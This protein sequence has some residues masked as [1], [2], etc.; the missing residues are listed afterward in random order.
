MKPELITLILNVVFLALLVLGFLFGL[1]GVKKATSSLCSFI[2][3][4]VV[5]LFLDAPIS[6]WVLSWNFSGKS[7]EMHILDAINSMFGESIAANE[8]MQQLVKGI[9]LTLISILV[10]IVLI[11]VLGLIFKIIGNIVYRLIFGKDDKKTVEEVQIVNDVPQMTKK[12]VSPKKH[13]LLGGCIGLVHGFLLAFVLFMPLV[14]IVNIVNEVAGTNSASAEIITEYN[15]EYSNVVVLENNGSSTSFELKPAKD[16]LKEYL[17]A[18]FYT[19]ASALDNSILAKVGKVGNMSEVSLNLVA[20]TQINGETIKLGKELR[21]IVKV[22]DEFVDFATQAASTLGTTDIEVIF[23]DIVENPNNYDFNKLY[24]ICDDLFDSGLVKALGNDLLKTIA[25]SLVESNKANTE[26][27]PYLLHIQTA[28]NNYCVGNYK[29]KDDV[30]AFLGAFEISAKSGLIKAIQTQPFKVENLATVLLNEQTESRPK[31]EVLTN[32]TGKITSSNLL[33]KAVIEATNYGAS[34]LQDLMNGNIKFKEN[35]KVILPKIDGSKDIRVNSTELT[36]LIANAYK[37]YKDVYEPL[38]FDKISQDFLN[39]FDYDLK[40]MINL[41]GE[42]IDTIVNMQIFKDT[43][44]FSSICEAMSNSEYSAYISFNELAVGSNIKN[45]FACLAEGVNE[46]KNSNIV[47]LIKNINNENQNDSINAIISELG[48]VGANGKVLSTRILSPVLTCSILKNTFIYGLNEAHNALEY[49]LNSLVSGEDITLAPFNTSG[50]ISET[51]NNQIISLVE[52]L[53]AYAKD[54]RVEKLQGNELLDTIMDSNLTALGLALDEAKNANLFATTKSGCLYNDMMITLSK[55]NFNT[56]IDFTVALE[57]DFSWK[58]ELTSLQTAINTINNVIKVPTADGEKGLVKFMLNGGDFNEAYNSLN[59]T[60]SRTLQPI[61]EIKLIKPIAVNIVNTINSI[62]K[63]FVGVDLGKDIKEITDI[64]AVD[65]ASQSTEITD[66]ISAAVDIDFNEENLDN[67]DKAKLNILLAKL[68]VN[69]KHNGVFKDSYNALLLKVADMINENIKSFVGNAGNKIQTI[70]TTSDVLDYSQNIIAVLNSALDTVKALKNAEFKDINTDQLIQFIN[71][72]YLNSK[73]ANNAFKESF[74]ALNVYII[75]KV[76]S[77][78]AEFV[79]T[80]LATN[81]VTYDGNTNIGSDYEYVQ[82]IVKR[83]VS[84]YKAIPVG[85]ELED[86][87]SDTLDSL[88]RALNILDYTKPAY[89]ALNNKL[90]NVVTENINK[91]TGN[92]VALIT[93]VKD[94]TSQA[95]DIKNIVDVCLEVAPK[96]DGKSFKLADMS[97]I[98]KANALKLLNAIQTNGVKTDGVFKPTYDSLVDFI[99]TTNGTTS[100]AIYANFATDGVIDWNSFINA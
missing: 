29:L 64:K 57:S 43:N 69:A 36:N 21:T 27:M 45:Q 8:T 66:V 59:S 34:Y 58:T 65:I 70:V 68:E 39:I 14:G 82:I 96:L 47:P 62:I 6:R 49:S 89:N 40:P 80:D 17:P 84:A 42:E 25:D 12:T 85:G 2:I 3:T 44:L 53:V 19:Y 7:V 74:N 31:N 30:K 76:N 22:Y 77:Q 95:S 37:I 35:A 87:D 16:L 5:V 1:K 33:Q 50:L 9:P 48:V 75:N 28:V 32:L 61:F 60:N 98:D 81:I 94:L 23:N 20:R 38:D 99:A 11:L 67:I 18:E 97:D 46:L 71:V 15:T 55:S 73:I 100:E 91:I 24:T 10:C 83:A 13:R 51:D 26:I 90:A 92:S 72:L 52:K 41:V 93:A 4:M 63:D 54:I 56:V 86:I 79:G 78:I 88:L